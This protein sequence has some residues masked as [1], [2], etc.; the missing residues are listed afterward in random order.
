[1]EGLDAEAVR[2]AAFSP[3]DGLT[4]ARVGRLEQ[5]TT[6]SLEGGCEPFRTVCQVRAK[7]GSH[8]LYIFRLDI[9]DTVYPSSEK[10]PSQFCFS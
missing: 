2:A 6:C 3:S 10:L 8:M 7:T 5:S 1:M 9:N 4:F